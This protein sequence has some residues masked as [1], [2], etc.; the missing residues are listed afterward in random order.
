MPTRLRR[1][2]LLGFGVLVACSSEAPSIVEEA[3]P[4]P[5]SVADPELCEE[6]GVLESVCPKCNP[7]L[8]A[9]FQSKGDWCEEHEFPE[10]FCPICSPE[11]GGRPPLQP[12]GTDGAPPEGTLVRFRSPEVEGQAGL[13]VVEAEAHDWVEGIEVVARIRWDTT[14]A[15]VVSARF[16]GVVTRVRAEE[17]E[18]VEAGQILAELRSAEVAGHRSR[19]VA[20]LEVRDVKKAAVDRKAR[21]LDEGV[22]S[23]RSLLEAKEELAEAESAATALQALVDLAGGGEGDRVVL[24][25]PLSGLVV[26]RHVG[27]GA[28]LDA[29]Q[30]LFDLVDPSR[31]WAELD[32][33]EQQLP[34]VTRGQETR[35]RIDAFPGLEFLGSI[36]A[37]AP[38][39]DPA[40]RT[41]WARVGLDNP[42][43]LLRENL[44]GAATVLGATA[45]RAVV[46]PAAAVQR[47]G[48]VHLVFVRQ[49][50]GVYVAKRVRVLAREGDRVRIAGGVHAGDPV[51]TTGSF[52]LKTETLK[53]SI[54]AGCCDVE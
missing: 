38:A 11:L 2:G 27:A 47:V 34:N 45:L 9:V 32:V 16:P 5:A 54:G 43:G 31:V 22:G 28:T 3:A 12:T 15:A 40:T 29:E 53:D 24:R 25:S 35:V 50:Q 20:A 21:L 49:Q 42:E 30:T 14:R 52:L 4:V 6:H 41:A 17:G 10:S 51:V 48:E 18:L 33:P 1:L 36:D 44:Y 13:E 39:V 7:Q 8:A 19:L 23:E 37:L 46:V 26:A